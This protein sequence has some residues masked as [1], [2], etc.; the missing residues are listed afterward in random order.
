MSNSIDRYFKVCSYLLIGMGFATLVLTGRVDIPSILLYIVALMLSW[1]SDR[2]ESK[3]QISPRTANWLA[4]SFLP[5]IYIDWRFISTSYTGPLIHYS[6]FISIFNL[7]KIKADRDWVFLYLIAI[8]EVLLAA[9]LTIDFVFIVMLSMFI[10]VALATLEAFEIR[11]SGSEVFQPKEERLL[12]RLGQVL[13]LRRIAYLVGV[14]FVMVLMIGAIAGPI[15]LIIPRFNSGF[16]AQSFGSTMVTIT[17]FSDIVELGDVGNIKKNNQVVMNVRVKPLDGKSKYTPKWRGVTLSHYDGKTWRERGRNQRKAVRATDGLYNIDQSSENPQLIE[18]VFYLEP[19][20]TPVVFVAS[21]PLSLTDQLP[22]L[23][24]ALSETLT[25]S[26]HSYKQITYTAVSDLSRPTDSELK[27]DN[28]EYSEEIMERYLQLPGMDERV[29]ELAKR[30]TQNA[31]TRLEKAQAIEQ[32]LKNNFTY[33][34][35]LKRTSEP[36]PL[37]DFLFNLKEGH[38]EYFASSMVILLRHA[39]VAARMVNGF[40]TGE[41]NEVGGMYSVKQSDAH[42]WVEVY[43]PATDRWIEFDPTPSAGL[44]QYASGGFAN[45]VRKYFDALRMFWLDYVV[46]YDAQRQSY[47]ASTIQQTIAQYKMKADRFQINLRQYLL[48]FISDLQK[49][50]FTGRG[51]LPLAA[52]LTLGAAIFLLW[53][54]RLIIKNWH[55]APGKLFSSWLG[56]LL[57]LPWLRWRTRANPQQSAVLFYNEMLALLYR[58]GINKRPEQTPREF[59]Q[60]VR[61]REVKMITDCYNAVRFSGSEVN[62]SDLER[63]RIWL[64]QLHKHK[65]QSDP[66]V[67]FARRR[68]MAAL[69]IALLLV[70]V[71]LGGFHFYVQ[72]NLDRAARQASIQLGRIEAEAEKSPSTISEMVAQVRVE[73][74]NGGQDIMTGFGEMQGKPTEQPPKGF[75]RI[76]WDDDFDPAKLPPRSELQLFFAQPQIA[77]LEQ[78]GARTEFR[79]SDQLELSEQKRL[80]A[81][82]LDH[83]AVIFHTDIMLWKAYYFMHEGNNREC[84]RELALLVSVGDRLMRDYAFS[85]MLL[86]CL[87]TARGSLA[88]SKFY[89]LTGESD[90]ARRWF[91]I[92]KNYYNRRTQA[93][94]LYKQIHIAGGSDKQLGLLVRLAVGENR[95]LAQE[96]INAIGR[97]WMESPA[98]I[99]F[100]MPRARTTILENLMLSSDKMV[101]RTA[102]RHL[103][104]SDSLNIVE[105]YARFKAAY[106]RR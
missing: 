57:V 94:H 71:F 54:L 1:K 42:S 63:V 37:V 80:K 51:S 18:Q 50:D 47:L 78:A 13:P 85:N 90:K 2:A 74:G 25:T 98:A 103:I 73:P 66:T 15:F 38:C 46:T 23:Y 45:N 83:D 72:R 67:M 36:D 10:L 75:I 11:R 102:H 12:N 43:F 56:R 17:G 68:Y 30:I 86:G 60:E 4:L 64:A 49:G 48:S 19:L 88:L 69:S 53:R 97:G 100:G 65:F 7:F 16:M 22:T 81:E 5:F 61:I 82:K 21:R 26:D 79:L 91:R 70:P 41:Y 87:V 44:S 24:R 89:L 76:P 31:P 20:N 32:Y 104:Q 92:A 8:F 93:I 62:Q 96:A 84:Q 3:L 52:V 35:D 99:A 105:R 58:H 77:M 9:T 29:A 27:R 40:Q 6:L 39:G 59:A 28:G 14:T 55:I 34:L 106:W 33:T 95:A 101:A